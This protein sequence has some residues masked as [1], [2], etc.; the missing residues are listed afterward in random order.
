MILDGLRE[1]GRRGLRKLVVLTARVDGDGM[2]HGTT[3][4]SAATW[5]VCP[6]GCTYTQIG[7]AVRGRKQRRHREHRPWRLPGRIHD[8]QEPDA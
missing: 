5:T 6:S 1:I 2:A 8:R 3:S 7:P 4:A